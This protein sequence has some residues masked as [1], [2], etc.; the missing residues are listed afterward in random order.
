MA[1]RTNA[2]RRK[3]S[4]K[5]KKSGGPSGF[6]RNLSGELVPS[7][8]GK[9]KRAKPKSVG[10]KTVEKLRALVDAEADLNST[11]ILNIE[12]E[13][14]EIEMKKSKPKKETAFDKLEKGPQGGDWRK[15]KRGKGRHACHSMNSG[16][17]SPISPSNT[18]KDSKDTPLSGTSPS[19][20][21]L[22]KNKYDKDKEHSK[23]L[24]K[25]DC[26]AHI[27]VVLDAFENR[28]FVNTARE[29]IGVL[30]GNDGFYADHMPSSDIR[31]LYERGKRII[32]QWH[33]LYLKTTFDTRLKVFSFTFVDD[34]FMANERCGT[35]EV[36]RFREKVANA[37]RSHT[38]LNA[39]F[40]VENAPIVNYPQDQKGKVFSIHVHGI[41]WG[42]DADDPK[43]LITG[44]KGFKSSIT[45]LPIHT[46]PVGLFEGSVSRLARYDAKPPTWGKEVNFDLLAAGERSLYPC[47]RMQLYHHLRLFEYGAKLPME[48]TMFGVREGAFMRNAVVSGIKH[49]QANRKGT[50]VQI[51]HRV[52][53]FFEVFLSENKKLKNYQPF[54]VN[55]QK[56]TRK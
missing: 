38:S 32:D 29:D 42:Y 56:S 40:V 17:N 37:I 31:L 47:K 9:K 15:T 52:D 55:W 18:P 23:K 19:S 22:E 28:K 35:A 16:T 30:L 48:Q 7:R 46:K 10:A 54:K 49:W 14:K 24:L 45:K 53:E 27:D 1:R 13:D 8:S 34:G 41:G 20:A 11:T 2:S 4:Q 50:E 43:K 33:E 5:K 12:I 21:N 51:G 39:F 44:A 36:Y 25:R 3:A 6:R 26:K